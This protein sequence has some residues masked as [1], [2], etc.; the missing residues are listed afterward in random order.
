VANFKQFLS[1]LRFLKASPLPLTLQD[2][3]D[4]SFLVANENLR[5]FQGSDKDTREFFQNRTTL[6]YNITIIEINMYGMD[7]PQNELG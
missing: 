2:L 1:A 7:I 4:I 5:R 6:M 3:L